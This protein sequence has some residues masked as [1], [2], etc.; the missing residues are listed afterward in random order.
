MDPSPLVDLT[1]KEFIVLEPMSLS[2]SLHINKPIPIPTESFETFSSELAN[3][4]DN[5]GM[6]LFC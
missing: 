2:N 1:N 6:Y 5:E 3:N 4:Y